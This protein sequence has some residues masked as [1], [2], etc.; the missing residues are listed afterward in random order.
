AAP[1]WCR[2]GAPGGGHADRRGTNNAV[3]PL[4]D[5]GASKAQEATRDY[6]LK[7]EGEG[8]APL[9]NVFGGKLT[10]DLLQR[11]FGKPAIGGE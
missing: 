5:D 2:S 10:T 6:L 8:A 9:L 1:P 7:L 3:R 4:Y 11:M